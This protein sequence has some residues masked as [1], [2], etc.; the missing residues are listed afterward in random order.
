MNRPFLVIRLCP[1]HHFGSWSSLQSWGAHLYAESTTTAIQCSTA[2]SISHP[3]SG[4]SYPFE[5]WAQSWWLRQLMICSD[6]L[7][8]FSSYIL[9]MYLFCLLIAWIEPSF[10]HRLGGLGDGL[11]PRRRFRFRLA[12]EVLY[13]Q[14]CPISFS[15]ARFHCLDVSSR[16]SMS[17]TQVLSRQRMHSFFK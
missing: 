7:V 13:S 16:V 5:S 15:K 4:H 6:L 10:S 14:S 1:C 11:A 9:P 8:P 3:S 12:I 2:S 17:R